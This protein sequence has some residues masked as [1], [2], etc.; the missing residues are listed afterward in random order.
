MTMKKPKKSGTKWVAM[1]PGERS[2]ILVEGSNPLQVAEDADK[3]GVPYF[4]QFIPDP[5]ITYI[6]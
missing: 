1:P 6:L 4:M 2:R 5:K 3:L